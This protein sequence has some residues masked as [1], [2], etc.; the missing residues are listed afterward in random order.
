MGV[1]ARGHDERHGLAEGH[2]VR[3]AEAEAAHTKAMNEKD[4][5]ISIKDA[6]V[7][8]KLCNSNGDAKRLLSQGAVKINNTHIRDKNATIQEKDFNKNYQDNKSYVVLYV[9]KKNY[10]II[11]LIS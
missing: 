10:G 7:E 4:L 8:L 3:R 9:G 2:E 5:Q 11:E 1:A 6:L